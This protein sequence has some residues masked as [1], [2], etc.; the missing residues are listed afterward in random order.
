MKKISLFAILLMAVLYGTP[1]HGALLL[2]SGT[3]LS[4]QSV[5]I[6]NS[7]AAQQI[8]SMSANDT[9]VSQRMTRQERR[10]IEQLQKRVAELVAI[11][12][13]LLANQ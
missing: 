3:P 11:L 10:Q 13:A 8:A 12:N 7:T 2:Q 1:A 5:A 6:D 4:N 9:P